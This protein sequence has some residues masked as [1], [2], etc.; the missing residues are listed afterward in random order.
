MFPAHIRRGRQ[1]WAG[2]EPQKSG[3]KDGGDFAE[4]L[5]GGQRNIG[6]MHGHAPF[7]KRPQ[8]PPLCGQ[9][10]VRRVNALLHTYPP[11][12]R[13]DGAGCGL[14]RVVNPPSI[15]SR[16]SYGKRWGQ[17]A[18]LPRVGR[19]IRQERG[20]GL[21]DRPG[22]AGDRGASIAADQLHREPATATGDFCGADEVLDQPVLPCRRPSCLRALGQSLVENLPFVATV[23]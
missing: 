14:D 9:R 13:D 20:R 10:V 19:N 2:A 1:L 16:H 8:R 3:G 23:P 21:Q 5:F 22:P 4:A 15:S 6:R 11:T 17:N 12:V 18:P 7:E